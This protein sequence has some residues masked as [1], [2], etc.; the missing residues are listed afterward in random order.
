MR[1]EGLLE[2]YVPGSSLAQPG[3]LRHLHLEEGGAATFIT[4][5]RDQWRRVDV[6]K[7]TASM[8]LGY[9]MVWYF[10]RQK[11]IEILLFW[12]LTLLT[13]SIYF[14]LLNHTNMV[15]FLFLHCSGYCVVHYINRPEVSLGTWAPPPAW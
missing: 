14:F 9:G 8:D 2:E 5:W 4:S 6:F 7:A 3:H 12:F 15:K 10:L 11:C 1:Y 13:N